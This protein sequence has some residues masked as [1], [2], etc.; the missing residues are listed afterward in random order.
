M[1][2]ACTAATNWAD[3]VCVG[4]ICLFLTAFAWRLTR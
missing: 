4:L 2:A 3:A 1:I